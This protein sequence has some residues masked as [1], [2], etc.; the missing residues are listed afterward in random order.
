MGKS[1]CDQ[2]SA[3]FCCVWP[4]Y[5]CLA[6][7][8]GN[9][10]KNGASGIRLW[11]QATHPIRSRSTES[12]REYWILS[13]KYLCFFMLTISRSGNSTFPKNLHFRILIFISACN[14]FCSKKVHIR[15]HRNPAPKVCVVQHC[16]RLPKVWKNCSKIFGKNSSNFELFF[17]FRFSS[18]Q[19]RLIN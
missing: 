11:R 5:K 17:R 13:G 19:R 3:D 10:S 18:S 15:I 4:F 12:P 8:W 7:T 1:F 6:T 14:V 16:I 2:F 9:S